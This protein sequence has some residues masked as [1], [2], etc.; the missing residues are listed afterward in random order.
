MTEYRSTHCCHPTLGTLTVTLLDPGT[1]ATMRAVL[2]TGKPA[3]RADI[4]RHLAVAEAVPVPEVKADQ[5]LVRVRATSLN[6]EDIMWGVG[7]RIGVYITATKEAPVI[8]GQE[9][10]GVVER[11]GAKVMKFKIGD[12][13]LGHKVDILQI[14]IIMSRSIFL[15]S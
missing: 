5:V 1:M 11:V 13:V 3:A 4:T 10:S 12:A 14:T 7:R 6:I 15:S 2:L 8:L 9:F